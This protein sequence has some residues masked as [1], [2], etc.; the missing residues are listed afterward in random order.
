MGGAAAGAVETFLRQWSLPSGC[1][2]D[3]VAGQTHGQVMP[4][5]RTESG[6]SDPVPIVARALN[7]QEREAVTIPP[8]T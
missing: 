1:A 4:K 8:P 6:R 5:T 7:L 2:G 3:R